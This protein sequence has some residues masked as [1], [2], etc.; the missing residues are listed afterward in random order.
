MNSVGYGPAPGSHNKKGHVP[1]LCICRVLNKYCIELQFVSFLSANLTLVG[2]PGQVSAIDIVVILH[3]RT[4]CQL[5]L[6]L[7][8]KKKRKSKKT[9]KIIQA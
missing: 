3:K 8:E 1:Y 4:S 6:N 7:Q 9:K 5:Q 2:T